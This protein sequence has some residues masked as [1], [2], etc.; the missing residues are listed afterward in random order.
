MMEG[1][2]V[3]LK[4]KDKDKDKDRDKEREQPREKEKEK[5]KEGEMEAALYANC[6]LLG[7]DAS[8]LGPGVGTRAG[9]FRHSNPRVGEAL[10]HFL[11]CAL[12][13]PY[14]SSKDFAG[15]WPIFDAAQSRDF[16]KIV[17]GLINELEAQ[18]ALPRSNSRV[19][20]LATCCGQ[21]F[22]ELLWQLSAHALREVHR[23]TFQADVAAN[24][25]PAPLTEVVSQNSHAAALLGVTKARIALERR[26]FLNGATM[27][28][29]RQDVWSSLA[30][31]MTAEYRSLC[32][33]EAYLHQEL[34]K[35]QEPEDGKFR[36]E[37]GGGASTGDAGEVAAD[38]KSISVARASQ[39]WGSLLAHT[40]QNEKLTSGPIEDLIAHRE[41]RYRIDG[42]VLRAAMDR[43]SSSLHADTFLDDVNHKLQNEEEGVQQS[44]HSSSGPTT[45]GLLIDEI[46]SRGEDRTAKGIISPLDVAEVLRRWTH[47]LQRIHKQAVRLARLNDGSG[48]ELIKDVMDGEENAHVHALHATLAEHRQHLANIQ[49]LM[50]QLKETLPG[51][52]EA[53]SGLRQ[54][55][56]SSDVMSG[57]NA[58]EATLGVS[59]SP[60]QAS[61]STRLPL[62]PTLRL[63]HL[64]MST[65]ER[66]FSPAPMGRLSRLQPLSHSFSSIQ[67]LDGPQEQDS[68]GGSTVSGNS[69]SEEAPDMVDDELLSLRQAIREAALS[70][71]ILTPIANPILERSPAVGS[72]HY[73]TPVTPVSHSDCT[74]E[75]V[76]VAMTGTGGEERSPTPKKNSEHIRSG[77]VADFKSGLQQQRKGSSLAESKNS[78]QQFIGTMVSERQRIGRPETCQDVKLLGPDLQPSSPPLILD[79]AGFVGTYDDL[80]APMS[81]WDAAIMD[82]TGSLSP[83]SQL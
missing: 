13:G 64:P 80:L 71:P 9:L 65:M 37:G 15:V 72:E 19:S 70:K 32:A 10:L 67:S 56:D 27:A 3:L 8:V 4:E 52:E 14:L 59:S 12:R 78:S 45:E 17:Q 34:E 48:P 20:S 1:L 5:E 82:S 33:E 26:R 11:L 76:F 81:A 25:L 24:P 53:I 39:L 16:R 55:V 21:R 63:P 42:A 30:H 47:A 28:V 83:S 50:E 35:L 49:V 69:G 6:L 74:R 62:S 43:D 66:T 51:M 68:F 38:V 29:R 36:A 23:R 40:E 61:I 54:Q 41:H 57:S 79:S 73:F 77:Y 31:D 7:L 75:S 60:P 22:V 2:T 44:S 18:G 58:K 46:R